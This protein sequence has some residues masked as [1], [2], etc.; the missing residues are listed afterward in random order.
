MRYIYRNSM[1]IV[2]HVPLI[3]GRW[4]TSL[5][6][7]GTMLKLIGNDGEKLDE[8]WNPPH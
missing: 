6:Q 1:I 5:A 4:N 7:I 3:Q 2:V 8:I